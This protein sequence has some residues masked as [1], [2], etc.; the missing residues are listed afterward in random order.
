VSHSLSH[1]H[2]HTHTLSLSHTHTQVPLHER[3]S[4]VPR[5]HQRQDMLAV[6]GLADPRLPLGP[7][8]RP[9]DGGGGASNKKRKG[10]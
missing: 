5:L 7:L 4:A 8:A 1:T 2:T 9:G 3:Q 6:L 10:R